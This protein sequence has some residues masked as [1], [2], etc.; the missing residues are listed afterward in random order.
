MHALAVI[1]VVLFHAEFSYKSIFFLGGYFGVD[2]CFVVSG[3]LITSIILKAM[4]GDKFF[5][6]E[7][8][9]SC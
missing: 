3:Y 4:K 1:A 9:Y 2:A 5:F 8:Y 7:F 6:K